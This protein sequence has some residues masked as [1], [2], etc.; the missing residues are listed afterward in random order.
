MSNIILDNA[1][2]SALGKGLKYAPAPDRVSK[3]K[4]KEAITKFGRR[5][6]IVH[7]FAHGTSFTRTK[8]FRLPSN[9]T[10]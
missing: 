5:V 9:W 2:K 7:H 3:D 10:P 6:R 1:Q 4:I 8:K